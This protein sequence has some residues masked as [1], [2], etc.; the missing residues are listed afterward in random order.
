MENSDKDF[1]LLKLKTREEVMVDVEDYERLNKRIWI[2]RNRKK[3]ESDAHQVINITWNKETK[4]FTSTYL[5][6]E[7]MQEKSDMVVIRKDFITLDFRKSNLIVCSR[8]QKERMRSKTKQTTTSKYKGVCWKKRDKRWNAKF[9]S[10]RSIYTLGI[11]IVRKM[12]HKLTMKQ[13]GNTLVI[14]FL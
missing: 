10:I 13:R 2:L 8:Q 5:P 6:R 3:N 1:R 14:V 7:V 12:L 11:S 4:K 9:I